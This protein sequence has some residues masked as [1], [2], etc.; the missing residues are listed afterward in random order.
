MCDLAAGCRTLHAFREGC[1]FC[2]GGRDLLTVTAKVKTR[3]LETRK[4][5]A[6]E[7]VKLRITLNPR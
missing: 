2:L 7:Y 6:P 5:A 3:T 1:G 4:G